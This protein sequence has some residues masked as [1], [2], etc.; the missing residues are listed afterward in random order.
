MNNTLDKTQTQYERKLAR[1]KQLD[2]MEAAAAGQ[3]YSGGG[4]NSS[5]SGSVASRNSRSTASQAP[6]GAIESARRFLWDE[7]EE[8]YGRNNGTTATAPSH[9]ASTYDNYDTAQQQNLM[10]GSLTSGSGQSAGFGSRMANTIMGSLFRGRDDDNT[11]KDVNLAPRRPSM[12]IHDAQ[13]REA[14]EYIEK[15]R[16]RCIVMIGECCMAIL[17]TIVGFF[18]ILCEYMTGCLANMNPQLCVMIVAA[19]TGIGLFIFAIVAIMHRS[20]GGGGDSSTTYSGGLPPILDE[21]RYGDIRSAISTSKFTSDRTL[22]TPGTAQNYALR[23]LTDED[24]AQL[25]ADDDAILQRYSLA[26]FYFSTYVYAEIVDSQSKGPSGGGW[27]YGDYWMSEKGICMWFGVS[28]PP[29]L[30]EGVEEVHY[31]ENSDIIRL[32][33]TD[34]NMRGIIPS[35]LSALE[36]LVSLDLGNNKLEG[37]VPPAISGLKELRKLRL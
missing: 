19:L 23:W 37:T 35:E 18:A 27:T 33:L 25:A 8:E 12:F 24:P 26:T 21:L 16:G 15:R 34:N 1:Q 11:T 6:K 3:A 29:H 7:D 32:N 17:H 4:E 36:N 9:S 2:M 22:D 10:G 20:K 28:C 30:K 13:P 31:N 5:E 14:E